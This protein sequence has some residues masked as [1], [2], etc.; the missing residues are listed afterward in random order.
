MC[1][2]ANCDFILSTQVN[3]SSSSCF[4]FP[5]SALIAEELQ[6]IFKPSTWCRERRWH[7]EEML[8]TS[9]STRDLRPVMKLLR[10]WHVSRF[11][12]FR[13]FWWCDVIFVTSQNGRNGRYFILILTRITLAERKDGGTSKAL[14]GSES[15]YVKAPPNGPAL[16]TYN[17][18]PHSHPALKFP[19]RSSLQLATLGCHPT[20]SLSLS[21]SINLYSLY[22]L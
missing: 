7:V 4:L 20:L 3:L 21:H 13:E 19:F 17:Y 18:A 5:A 1:P 22:T 11:V 15:T 10:S 16:S 12:R 6:R 9:V 8:D 2:I 14:P